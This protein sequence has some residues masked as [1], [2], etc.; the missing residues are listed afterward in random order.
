[1]KKFSFL[2][3][4]AFFA[5]A[6]VSAFGQGGG[7]AEANVIKFAKGKSSAV[8]AGTLAGDEEAEY[9]FGA[10]KG[11]IV[12]ILNPKSD[13]FSFRVF[14]T[15]VDY[16]SD[17]V[18]DDEFEFEVPETGNY[19]LFVKISNDRPQPAKYSLTLSIK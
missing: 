5:F 4:I 11:Q 16:N 10:R 9:V 7:K 15:D 3:A 14:N 17:D 2:A 1:M 19:M 6:A 18:T 12:K 13:V 8:I